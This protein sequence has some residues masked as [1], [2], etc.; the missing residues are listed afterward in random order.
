MDATVTYAVL[1]ATGNCGTALIQNLLEHAGAH[2]NI[3][4]RNKTKLIQNFPG[5]QEDKRVAIF[6][7]SIH[8]R[9]LLTTCVR[10]CRAIFLCISTNDNIPNCNLSQASAVAIVQTLKDLGYNSTSATMEKAPKLLLLSSGTIEHAFS[11]HLPSVLHWILLR[12]A[13][14]VYHDLV[15]AEKLLRAEES[16]LTTIYVKPGALSVDKKRGYELS[17][18]EQHSPISYL[19]LAAGM[20]EL[21]DETNGRW[22]FR[23]VS[24]N[25]TSDKAAFPNGTILCIVTGLLRHFFPWMHEYLPMGTGPKA[26]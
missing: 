6:E 12:S 24:V 15:E 5:I 18:T 22:D 16:W 7:G 17:L 14:H 3:Y 21:A 13:S 23:N 9:A 4:C 11:A 25:C 8:D 19:D 26:K 20:I 10:G 2:I 1:G